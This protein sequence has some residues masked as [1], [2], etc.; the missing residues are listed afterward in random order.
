MKMS[1]ALSEQELRDLRCLSGQM[2]PAT[3]EYGMPGADDATIFATIVKSLGRDTG[4]ARAVLRDLAELS[5]DDFAGLP[6]AQRDAAVT[7]LRA[8]AGASLPILHRVVLLCYYRDDRVMTSL[9]MEPRPP[10]PQGH[11]L[12]HGDWALLDPV[13]NRAKIWRDA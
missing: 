9:G 13:R 8:A 1:D 4:D 7:A 11:V 10:F 12:E 5:D 6:P 2:I 3:A